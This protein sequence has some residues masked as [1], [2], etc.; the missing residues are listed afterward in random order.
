MRARPHRAL[1]TPD[2]VRALLKV[3]KSRLHD[4]VENGA[5]EAIQ[6]GKQLRSRPSA[7]VRYLEERVSTGT[8]PAD[9]GRYHQAPLNSQTRVLRYG[10]SFLTEFGGLTIVQPHAG[11]RRH[12]T[13][14]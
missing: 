4:A 8:G 9:P 10:P 11:C 7:L 5:L 13:G 1:L 2:G 12:L 14:S 3:K 6:L